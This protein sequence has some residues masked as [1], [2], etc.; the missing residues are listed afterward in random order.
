MPA[1]K[2]LYPKSIWTSEISLRAQIKLADEKIFGVVQ[3]KKDKT[4]L[5]TV[6]YREYLNQLKRNPKDLSKI[7]TLDQLFALICYE[8]IEV[9]LVFPSREPAVRVGSNG[10]FPTFIKSGDVFLKTLSS[11]DF[12]FSL[13]EEHS[14]IFQPTTEQSKGYLDRIF[15][16]ACEL[17]RRDFSESN[18]QDIADLEQRKVKIVHESFE[19]LATHFSYEQYVLAFLRSCPRAARRLLP[20]TLLALGRKHLKVADLF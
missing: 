20:Q 14:L 18:F 13:F 16:S 17:G 10:G 19:N 3:S 4:A 11:Q 7:K 1:P 2:T 12:L 15:A 5:I 8:M 6:D 9:G